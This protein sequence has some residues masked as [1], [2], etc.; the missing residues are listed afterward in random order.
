MA[1]KRFFADGVLTEVELPER[2]V[3]NFTND[4]HAVHNALISPQNPAGVD[5]TLLPVNAAELDNLKPTVGASAVTPKFAEPLPGSGEGP[6]VGQRSTTTGVFSDPWNNNP[7]KEPSEIE[8]L[9]S[10]DVGSA[11]TPDVARAAAVTNAKLAAGGEAAQVATDTAPDFDKMTKPQLQ[12]WIGNQ[13]HDPVDGNKP[14]LVA[15]AKAIHE[16]SVNDLA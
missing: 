15:Q 5:P 16:D 13:Q 12:A 2:P 4:G 6:G 10:G 8:T 1:V 9:Q 11:L 3:P 7:H 14:D